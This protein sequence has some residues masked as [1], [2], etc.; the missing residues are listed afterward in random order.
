MKRFAKSWPWWATAVIAITVLLSGCA[1]TVP[2]TETPDLAPEIDTSRDVY[3]PTPVSGEE[4]LRSVADVVAKVKPSVVAIYTEITTYDIFD[5]AWTQEGAGSGWIIRE[6][7]CIVT[8]SHVVDDASRVIVLLDDGREFEAEAVYTDDWTDIAVVKIAADGLPVAAVGDS[9]RLRIGDPLVAIGNSLGL[10]LS[11][12]AGIT[13]ATGVS[14]AASPGQTLLDLVQTDAAINPGNSGGPLVNAA[15]EVIGI[16][17]I[18][19]AQIGVEGMG[20]AISINQA[21]P[22]IRDLIQHGRVVRAWLGISMYTVTSSVVS[23]FDL[24]VD[25]G[26]LIVDVVEGSPAEEAG[27]ESGDVIVVFGAR[28][29]RNTQDF[30]RAIHDLRPGDDVQMDFWR[31]DE[32][33]STT[34]RLGTSPAG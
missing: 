23:R 4:E 10:G 27:L 16:N 29:I 28:D 13:S 11:A 3:V 5:R 6:D 20:Y 14:L 15:G 31:G 25:S 22:I 34:A 1:P 24:T 18:K 8:N 30:T 12:T 32:R 19:I 26:V 17:S 7:G 21:M 9:S 2:E 33:M